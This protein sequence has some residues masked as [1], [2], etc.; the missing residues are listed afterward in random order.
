[1]SDS[2]DVLLYIL[3]SVTQ[4]CSLPDIH[5]GKHPNT[6]T[7]T[8]IDTKHTQTCTLNAHKHSTQNP[9]THKQTCTQKAHTKN[10]QR[11][12]HKTHIC[13]DMNTH[14]KISTKTQLHTSHGLQYTAITIFFTLKWSIVINRIQDISLSKNNI[15]LC[16]VDNNVVF[17]NT[18]TDMH[19]FKKNTTNKNV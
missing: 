13:T 8:D 14:A 19:I 5:W 2:P 6:H 4:T 16:S 11:L 1:M 7:C 15:C 12:A 10:T 3:M 18:Y 17:I 9:Q